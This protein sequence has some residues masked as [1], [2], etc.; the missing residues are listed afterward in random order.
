M[1]FAYLLSGLHARL[2]IVPCEMDYPRML[3]V[4]G[5]QICLAEHG[6]RRGAADFLSKPDAWTTALPTQG[7]IV[8]TLVN[9][10]DADQLLD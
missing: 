2:S 4:A 8:L 6:K 1:R 7:H 3:S 5:M 9:A 10:Q